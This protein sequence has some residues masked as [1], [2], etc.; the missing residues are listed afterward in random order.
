MHLN[1]SKTLPEESS[2]EATILKKKN[3]VYGNR[4]IK[5]YERDPTVLRINGTY[6]HL[7]GN[8]LNSITEAWLS[9]FGHCIEEDTKKINVKLFQQLETEG[10]A[11]NASVTL[12]ESDQ[13][14]HF[15]AKS[16]DTLLKY[17]FEAWRQFN[18]LSK[19]PDLN[20]FFLP[21]YIQIPLIVFLAFL[22]ALFS[23]LN[24]GL[25]SLSVSS[26]ELIIKHDPA[27]KQYAQNILPLRRNG[28]LLLC[29]ILIGN[30]FVNNAVTLLISNLIEASG[31]FEQWLMFILS[32][33]LP[34]AIIVFIGEIIPQAICCRYGLII[35]SRTRFITIFFIVLTFV[36][37]YPLSK[38]LDWLIGVE[39]PE[40]FD[41]GTLEHI[42]YMNVDQEHGFTRHLADIAR[43]A[44]QYFDVR[45]AADVMTIIEK[46]F[47]LPDTE[48][49]SEKLVRNIAEKGYT[50][51]PI[52]KN[53]N[54]NDIIGIINVKDLVPIDQ[55]C[56]LT[57]GT[58]LQIWQ[59]SK[60]FR[61]VLPD[62]YIQQLLKEMK[63]GQSMAFVIG[64]NDETKSYKVIG[65]I[66]L[67]DIIEELTGEIL[68][69]KD[70]KR[71]KTT[72]TQ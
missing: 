28:N 11:R 16:N 21:I 14:Y 42:I 2:T 7:I 48:I 36:V 71:T 22:S 62:F 37:S 72:V 46:V 12:P 30:T 43:R 9:T 20:N 23:G 32:V 56:G 35:G 67:E 52:Y 50:R 34:A 8:Y 49:I 5:R 54:K 38:I 19:E 44:L 15:C 17:S 24:V 70:I 4:V 25:M 6:F 66:A 1:S 61:F 41:V 53:E 65:I 47:M 69:E 27:K 58:V 10:F 60:H 18:K 33:L 40:S 31:N 3:I 64:F 13:I 51:I 68:D 57:I 26:L 29:T 39:G 55:K 63:R 59:R 45:R